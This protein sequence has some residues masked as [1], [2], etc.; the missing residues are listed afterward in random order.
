MVKNLEKPVVVSRYFVWALKNSR[1]SRLPRQTADLI[2]AC[3][4]F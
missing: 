1:L 4:Y 2:Y 3:G